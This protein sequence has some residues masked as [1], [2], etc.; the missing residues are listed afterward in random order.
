MLTS[1]GVCL[2]VIVVQYNHS[3]HCANVIGELAR[4]GV[5]QAVWKN[6]TNLSPV[7]FGSHEGVQGRSYLS[8]E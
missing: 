6:N 7:R 4:P 2:F 3:M 5:K 1:P 8:Q